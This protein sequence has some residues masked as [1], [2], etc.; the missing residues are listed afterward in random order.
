MD[1]I[2]LQQSHVLTPAKLL[3]LYRQLQLPRM[4]E[5]RMLSL[6][7]QGRLSKWFSGIGQEAI[8]V[9]ATFA[10][11]HNDVILPMHRNLGVFTTRGMD[12]KRLF[13]QLM[14]KSGGFTHGRD[15]SFHFGSPEHHIIGMISHLGAM[16]PVAD[17]YGAAFQMK[18]QKR[19]ALAFSG[20][21]ATSEGDFH[22]ALN[23]A[24]VWKLPVIFMI[25][26]NGYGL[27]TP[28]NE[29]YACKHLADRG[30]G[31]GI[32]GLR[33]DGNDVRQVYETVIYAAEKAR[34]GQGPT[35]IEAMTFRMRGH[36]EASGTKYVPQHLFDE[37]K[38]R[39]PVERYESFL[40]K[41]GVLSN[42]DKTAIR[43]ELA[44]KIE[45]ALEEALAAPLPESTTEK[46]MSS[47]YAPAL[48]NIRTPSYPPK[49]REMRY[50]DAV[51][52]ALREKMAS[53][54]SVLLIGQDIA[55]Y[56][57][58]FKVTEGFLERFG[59]MRVRNT[60]IIESGAI[61]AAM[62]LA[63]EGYKP[64][65]EMQ[66]ADFATCGFNQIV[67]NL[68]KTYY[69][70]GSPINVTIRMPYGGGVGAGPFHSQSPEAWFF[71]IPGL[72][73]LAPATPEDAKGLL[74]AALNDP[75]PVLFFEHKGLY[76]SIKGEVPEGVYQTEIGKAD[77]KRSGTDATIITYGIGVHWALEIAEII[78]KEDGAS[79]E[80]LDLRSLLPWDRD[81]VL[82]SVQK[83]SRALVLHE[84]TLT[85]GVGAEIAA[86]ITEHAFQ[87]LDAP[88]M[89]VA[90]LD[91]PVPFNP[92]LEQK[93]FWAKDRLPEKLR[94]LLN[95]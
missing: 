69:R 41:E 17:G 83:T 70:W 67:N 85:G 49:T 95:Y 56:G 50:V 46:E 90:S 9:G 62:G 3:D 80:V 31:Y 19:V 42:E 82:E 44:A 8:C 48:V 51:S 6:L 23:L 76:R 91:M 73:L 13:R 27:S 74:I 18:G 84:A 66:F 12:L 2:R 34:H 26:N 57:G 40:V 43:E 37:W 11:N 14:G 45:E 89:R 79:V 92:K 20:D 30:I 38:Q 94:Q 28:V 58:V 7:R 53:D 60:P 78:E 4:I 33:I 16:L 47:V 86:T 15:R 64:V 25:E 93:I 1:A 5:E 63:L 39:D 72:K 32:E 77:I 36:E 55:E 61:G 29:Q 71:H 10:L 65:V 21:G 81:A 75:N 54:A 59:K 52:D 24:A 35:L 68:A 22:E 88:V 87:S